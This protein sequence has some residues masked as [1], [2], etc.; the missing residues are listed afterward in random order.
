M[1]WN[2]M[3]SRAGGMALLDE[4]TRAGLQQ[5]QAAL[6]EAEQQLSRQFDTAQRQQQWLQLA[7]QLSADAEQ[8]NAARQAPTR[9][10]RRQRPI[11]SVWHEVNRQKNCA[12][13]LQQRDNLQ[14][15]RAELQ[16]R[17]QQLNQQMQATAPR[18]A[19]AAAALSGNRSGARTGAFATAPAGNA[20][21][22]T[23]YST[24]SGAS[25]LQQQIQQLQHETAQQQASC[26]QREQAMQTEQY[27]VSDLQQA[28]A[29]QQVRRQQLADMPV[30][31]ENLPLW[32]DRFAQLARH[33]TDQA[34]SAQQIQQ[35]A[36]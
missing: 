13:A 16:Q 8:V 10:V 34:A 12:G 7:Q 9:R 27:K 1:R 20:T 11:A 21:E 28:L 32:Q 6:T 25:A 2:W 24:R 29:Q 31:G 17:Q 22:R 3:R 18:A 33:E 36:L 15:E 23:G 19:A 5:Q 30:W 14:T 35:Q 26:T 4:A